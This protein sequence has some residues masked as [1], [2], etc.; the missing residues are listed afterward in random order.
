MTYLKN[1][2]H[3][4]RKKQLEGD[5]KESSNELKI[6]IQKEIDMQ[7]DLIK[8]WKRNRVY[9]IILSPSC[10]HCCIFHTQFPRFDFVALFSF[11]I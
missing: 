10:K 6:E 4:K 5:L 1:L 8:I 9:S 7:N 3:Q 2:S 11:G